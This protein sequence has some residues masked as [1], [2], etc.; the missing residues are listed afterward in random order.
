MKLRND[1]QLLK[2]QLIHKHT[3]RRLE[4][5]RRKLL[6]LHVLEQ[7]LFEDVRLNSLEISFL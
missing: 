5:K 2:T 7:N 4:L 6:L 1:E 3:V